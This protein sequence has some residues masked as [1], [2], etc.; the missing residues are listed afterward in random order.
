MKLKDLV[1]TTRSYRRFDEKKS[2]E[3]SSLMHLVDLGR[4][5]ASAKNLQ[6]IRYYVSNDS[7]INAD[8]FPCL[9]WAGYIKNWGGPKVG[10]RPTG[11]IILLEDTAVNSRWIA[12]DVGIAAQSIMLGATEIGLG[13]CIIAAINKPILRKALEI[14]DHYEIHFVLALGKPIEK[15]VLDPIEPGND[16]KYWRDAEN[17][18]HVPKRQL[19]DIIIHEIP[20]D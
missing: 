9:G 11:Y 8:I 12:H 4:L 2:V 6:P 10:E 14:P 16:I 5:S 19:K 20:G 18:H 3:I 1:L 15:V 13:G 7:Q 17:V